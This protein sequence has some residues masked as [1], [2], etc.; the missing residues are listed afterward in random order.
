[1][2]G[3]RTVLLT[4]ASGF[5]GRHAQRHL[6]AR[7]YEV[8]ATCHN[9]PEGWAEAGVNA[10]RCDLLD[11][12][13]S[14]A[15]MQRVRPTH[16]LH[17]AW[18]T[19]PGTY[20]ESPDNLSWTGA[21]L[22][23][24]QDFAQC[25][26]QRAVIAGSCAE[27]DW[28]FALAVEGQTPLNP[29]SL[30]GISK[31]AVRVIA[32]KFAENTSVSLGWG[33][34]YFPY[35][36]H[37]AQARLVPSVIRALLAGEPALCTHGRQVRDFIY[38]DDAAAAFAALL[39]SPVE[40]AVNIATG[41]AGPLHELIMFIGKELQRPELIELGAVAAPARDVENLTADV[42]RLNDEVGFTPAVDLET[43]LR[44]SIAWWRRELG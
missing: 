37:E 7:G 6:S 34:L 30:Y 19:A 2:S 13:A 28:E 24:L 20:W 44:K 27:Y 43:G 32:E 12:G 16:L 29:A 31:N 10:H 11:A 21:S 17:L 26:G 8:H 40:G 15:L 25:G 35:G 9:A 36:P 22:Q 1:M 42:T 33:R 18:T 23:L 14:R 4:G 5:V 41:R 39:D 38:V 3:T